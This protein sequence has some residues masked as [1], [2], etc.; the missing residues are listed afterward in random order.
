MDD[1]TGAP[2]REP[3]VTEELSYVRW[4]CVMDNPFGKKDPEKVYTGVKEFAVPGAV[5]SAGFLSAHAAAL[6]AHFGILIEDIL[7]TECLYS[8]PNDHLWGPPRWGAY[9]REQ[10]Y[11]FIWFSIR[12]G[13]DVR[14]GK[15]VTSA[16]TPNFFIF[17]SL[18]LGRNNIGMVFAT[19]E[20]ARI[21]AFLPEDVATKLSK[22]YEVEGWRTMEVKEIHPS[23]LKANAARAAKSVR[24]T[25]FNPDGSIPKSI[26]TMARLDR[27]DYSHCS[28]DL[29]N[30]VRK[31][32]T[33]ERSATRSTSLRVWGPGPPGGPEMPDLGAGPEGEVVASGTTPPPLV[34][35][36]QI[37]PPARL[38]GVMDRSSATAPALP[39]TQSAGGHQPTPESFTSGPSATGDPPQQED[40]PAI[41]SDGSDGSGDEDDV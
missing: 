23:V 5:F 33:E 19:L 8:G 30:A 3:T 40:T 22:G 28:D 14:T 21:F 36:R 34:V 41:W 7:Y 27:L 24:K 15:L 25:Q 9:W 4:R 17:R 29:A 10:G 20:D 16:V 31:Q 2:V 32:V 37:P 11:R 12:R 13:R 39:L 35:A 38:G 26:L 1:P 6:F 18:M